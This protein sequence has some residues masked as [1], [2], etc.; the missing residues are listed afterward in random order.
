MNSLKIKNNNKKK[1]SSR[2]LEPSKSLVIGKP[3][4][5]L[6]KRLPAPNLRAACDALSG[7]SI[8][9]SSC[10]IKLLTFCVN[11]LMWHLSP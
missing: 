5:I 1:R 11:N 10:G 6:L 7:P 9:S 8:L 2:K 4:H 3:S